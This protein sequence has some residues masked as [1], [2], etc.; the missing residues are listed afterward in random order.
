MQSTCAVGLRCSGS[1]CGVWSP[2]TQRSHNYMKNENHTR[3]YPYRVHSLI[4]FVIVWHSP[5]SPISELL[6]PVL[7]AAIITVYT[8]A[9]RSLPYRSSPHAPHFLQTDY[10]L[11]TPACLWPTCLVWSL[12]N[13]PAIRLR[14]WTLSLLRYRVSFCYSALPWLPGD[15]RLAGCCEHA[16]CA[17]TCWLPPS[18]SVGLNL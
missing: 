3:W 7:S 15:Q 11:P 8:L 1:V 4:W 9:S 12:V 10:L 13:S 17:F 6:S 18:F 2:A 16:V 5:S 14:L